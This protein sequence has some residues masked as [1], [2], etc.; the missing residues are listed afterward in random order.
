MNLEEIM[1]NFPSFSLKAETVSTETVS[2][3]RPFHNSTTAVL[4]NLCPISSSDTVTTVIVV[5]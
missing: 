1:S 3:S 2:S 4:K 5:Y